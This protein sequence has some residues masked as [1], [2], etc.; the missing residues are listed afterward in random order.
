MD[1]TFLRL[2]GGRNYGDTILN[3][4]G[5]SVHPRHGQI[6]IVSPYLVS[7]YLGRAPTILFNCGTALKY[8]MPAMDRV[9]DTAK[10]VDYAGLARG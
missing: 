2:D 4:L 7:P 8:P 6:S 10:P 5:S 1:C 3:C 9:L